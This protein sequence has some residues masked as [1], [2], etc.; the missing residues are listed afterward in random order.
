MIKVFRPEIEFCFF[1][2]Y[3]EYEQFRNSLEIGDSIRLY[4]MD[5][6]TEGLRRLADI[7]NAEYQ[8]VVAVVSGKESGLVLEERMEFWFFNSWEE[9]HGYR[10]RGI[11][12]RSI[13]SFSEWLRHKAGVTNKE[14]TYILAMKE[15]RGR[16]KSERNNE[17]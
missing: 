9:M 14:Y 6:F 10:R 12:L 5:P 3:H 17:R 1:K 13:N 15:E 11:L 2:T 8:S 4:N 7:S 16:K